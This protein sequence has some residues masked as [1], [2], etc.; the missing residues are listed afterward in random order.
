MNFKH[1]LKISPKS[2]TDSTTD[3][4]LNSNQSPN[5]SF[6]IYTQ[7][8]RKKIPNQTNQNSHNM[9][10]ESKEA[11]FELSLEINQR[12]VHNLI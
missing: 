8:R 2:T 10:I 5:S 4:S 6:K 3:T 9:P 12:I 7:N 11:Y 1:E